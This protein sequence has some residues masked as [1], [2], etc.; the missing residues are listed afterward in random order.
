MRPIRRGRYGAA[1]S[2]LRLFGAADSALRIFGAGMIRC[3]DYSVQGS[4]GAGSIRRGDDS[5]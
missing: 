4:F 5:A 2:E 1:D 3:R